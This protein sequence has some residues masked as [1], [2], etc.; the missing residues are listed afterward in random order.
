MEGTAQ[1]IRRGT[2]VKCLKRDPD[3]TELVGEVT[4]VYPDLQ[5]I[6]MRGDPLWTLSRE[7]VD[8]KHIEVL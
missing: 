2:P 7:N 4:Y 3:D 8:I 6:D 1:V 5:H